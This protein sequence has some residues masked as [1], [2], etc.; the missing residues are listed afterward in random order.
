MLKLDL[1]QCRKHFKLFLN[2]RQ[3]YSTTSQT[4][5]INKYKTS[6]K[7]IITLRMQQYMGCLVNEAFIVLILVKG[8]SVKHKSK[9]ER[10]HLTSQRGI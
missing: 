7:Q 9:P 6:L 4:K 2:T 3:N 1:E 10:A 8:I 5:C